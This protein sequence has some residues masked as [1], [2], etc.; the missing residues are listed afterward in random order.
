[1]FPADGLKEEVSQGVTRTRAGA[2]A[3]MQDK[4]GGEPGDVGVRA[5][6][7]VLIVW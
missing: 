5:L 7:Q 1:M 4:S 3:A 6:S 2:R